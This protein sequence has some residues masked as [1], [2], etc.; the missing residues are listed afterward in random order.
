MLVWL[1]LVI[2]S[3]LGHYYAS[4][5]A[6]GKSAKVV[7]SFVIA[8]RQ[9]AKTLAAVNTA[10]II[11]STLL[12]FSNVFDNCY[13]NSSVIG[14]GHKAYAVLHLTDE[15]LKLTKLCWAGGMIMSSVTALFFVC[16]INLLRKQ[17][18][19]RR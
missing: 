15:D 17:P 3:G 2:S 10:W 1:L 18:E 5:K 12:Q 7:G 8:L 4:Q 6:C 16:A 9:L 14:L 11:V 13:C 19:G